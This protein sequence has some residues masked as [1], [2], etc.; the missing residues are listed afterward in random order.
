MDWVPRQQFWEAVLVQ[1]SK[2]TIAKPCPSG[3]ELFHYVNEVTRYI[4]KLTWENLLES[5]L[6]DIESDLEEELLLSG[7]LVEDDRNEVQNLIDRIDAEKST[8]RRFQAI[9]FPTEK[10]NLRCTYCYEDFAVGKM[11]EAVQ[12]Q[13][14]HF[15]K[16]KSEEYEEI[17]LSWFGGEPLLALDVIDRV[18]RG[19]IPHLVRK[20]VGFSS[21]ITTNAYYLDA[22]RR[23]KLL[24][25]GVSA[26]Q[27]TLDGVRSD[28]NKRRRMNPMS[29]LDKNTYDVIL[30]NILALADEPDEFVCTIRF[31]YDKENVDGIKGCL[32]DLDASLDQRFQFDFSPVWADPEQYP[33]EIFEGIE[34]HKSFISTNSHAR[35]CGVKTANDRLHTFGGEVCYAANPH[36]VVV[37]SNGRL[38]KCTVAL[39]FD[40][41]QVGRLTSFGEADLDASLMNE[42]CNSGLKDDT[43]C[44]T[45]WNAPSCQGDSCP[46]VRMTEKRRPCTARKT[47]G[48]AII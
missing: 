3:Y 21:Q 38:N 33:F 37:R 16:S 17:N 34:R 47:S 15:L 29:K 7:L 13:L 36:S 1:I 19:L 39:D 30:R 5:D 18:H 8:K 48:T 27:I 22:T 4:D 26:F 6:G 31:N 40:A 2:Y 44:Q 32:S 45:C 25:L 41:N 9:V 28:H 10:C 46:L 43:G 20:R 24:A 42:W 14:I 12:D 23:K 11:P 35:E